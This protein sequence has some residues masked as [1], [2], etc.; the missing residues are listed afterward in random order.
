VGTPLL[1]S[2]PTARR[3]TPAADRRLLDCAHSNEAA[4]EECVRRWLPLAHMLAGRY[5]R[6]W[7]QEDLDQVAALAL[8]KAIDRFD[9][10]R[11]TAFTSF[12]VPTIEGELKRYL[13]DH[14]W[15]VRVPRAL[16]EFTLAVDN[17][18]E[19][20]TR[21][22]GRPPTVAQIAKRLDATEEEVLE[23]M[24]ARGA[25]DADSLDTPDRTEGIPLHEHVGESE[26]GYGQ[27]EARVD[28][29]ALVDEL[30]PRER[31]ILRLR[32]VEDLTQSEI[33]RE[34]GLSQMQVSRLIRRS[35]E[36]LRELSE[37]LDAA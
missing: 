1:Q 31:R 4:R 23:A 18:T 22:L 24:E 7:D 17:T 2:H 11:G 35:L 15:S 32:F 19:A 25:K 9:A 33:G 37:S 12:A 5:S 16:Q 36:E 21:Q 13:R 30:E 10:A 14:S 29:L 3:T 28:A 6:R 34:V 26:E 20:L 8:L 27:A